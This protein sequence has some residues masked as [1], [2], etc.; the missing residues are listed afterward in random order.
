MKAIS[1]GVCLAAG[2]LG[3]CGT[4]QYAAGVADQDSAKPAEL[5]VLDRLV[6]NWQE[7]EISKP[8][9]WTPK[10]ERTKSTSTTEWVLGGRF[11]QMKERGNDNLEVVQMITY[12]VDKKVYRRWRFTSGGTATETT[13]K[14]D[15]D[16][17]TL[18]WTGTLAK[19]ISF[20]SRWKMTSKDTMEGAAIA[21]DGSG[22]VYLDVASKSTRRK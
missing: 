6:G 7:E 8:A 16:S 15:E 17:K 3:L 14:W 22:K 10:E 18:T 12:D 2:L 9:E 20:V 1:M 21:K 11:V 13:G 4:F 19:D 5:K